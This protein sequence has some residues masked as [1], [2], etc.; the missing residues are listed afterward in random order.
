[1]VEGR[2]LIVAC[3]K[4]KR[5]RAAAAL[6]LYDGMTYRVLKRR[7]RAGF[8]RRAT[9]V[10]ILS[11]EHGLIAPTEVIA[12]YDRKMDEARAHELAGG[13]P[14]ER[15][16]ALVRGLPGWPHKEVFCCGGAHYRSVIQAYEAA[17]LFGRAGVAYSCGVL[18]EQLAQLKR[19]LEGRA[20]GGPGNG[21]AK[22]TQEERA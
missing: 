11:A 22:I 6:E 1:M 2:L 10:L 8:L 5:A 18:G 16:R 21:R 19:F 12:P 14:R 3:S 17:G 15:A 20:P 13:R 4:R 7:N 9:E